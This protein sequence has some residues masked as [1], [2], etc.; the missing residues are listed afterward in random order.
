[1]FLAPLL[2][3]AIEYFSKKQHLYFI[4]LFAGV[5]LYM[6]Y[7]RETGEDTWGTSLSHFLWLYII[8]RY[9]NKYGDLSFIQ[10]YRW[11]WLSGF[12]GLV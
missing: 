4:M 11:V 9:I 8:A 7:C 1:M 3:A 5:T 2:N 10:R 6:G 12:L